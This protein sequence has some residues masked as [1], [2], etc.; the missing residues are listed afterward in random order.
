MIGSVLRA[1]IGV[2]RVA[3]SPLIGPR[4]RFLPTCSDYASQALSAHQT[5]HALRL[6]AKRIARCHPLGPSGID[7]VPSRMNCRCDAPGG[8]RSLFTKA[9]S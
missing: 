8:R 7:E 4:C 3:V 9:S 1:L 6:I 5:G 2:Y